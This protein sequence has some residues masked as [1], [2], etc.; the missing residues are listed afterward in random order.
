MI[1]FRPDT[2]ITEAHSAEVL[3]LV[4]LGNAPSTFC[5]MLGID[6]GAP[7]RWAF[8]DA[9]F[10]A[11]YHRAKLIGA[12]AMV[13]NCVQIADRG[14]LKADAKKVMIDA[15]MKL[16]AIWNP[17][18]YGPQADKNGSQIQAHIHVPYA[19][20][21]PEKKAAVDKFFGTDDD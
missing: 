8:D 2:A 21:S 11:A 3:R 16:A 18:R 20:L 17:A 12:D 10:A 6:S 7:D 13:N 15:R 14:D 5:A 19:E 1:D 4:R 9:E